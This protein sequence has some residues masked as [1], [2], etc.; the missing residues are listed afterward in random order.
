MAAMPYPERVRRGFS[1]AA[2]TYD[3]HAGLQR[4]VLAETASLLLPLLPA[5]ARILDAGSGT[6]YFARSFQDYTV[7]QLDSA[8]GMCRAAASF[9]PAVCADM[10]SLP[11]RDQ[12][13]EA[14]VS[15]LALQWIESPAAA[16]REFQ[17]VTTPGGHAA[18]AT[19]GPATLKELTTC[20]TKAGLPPSVLTFMP[21]A[22]LTEAASACGW[23]ITKATSAF[24]LQPYPSFTHLLHQLK[25]LGATFK[26][27]THPLTPSQLK[28][29][30]AH[31]PQQEQNRITATFE[32][33]TLLLQKQK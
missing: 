25:G 21:Q 18:I 5:D 14:V 6:G 2:A 27:R 12:S 20:F 9:A 1:R 30:E 23:Q 19:L 33:L 29:L 13:V 24:K 28:R 8:E 22:E 11:L 3:L 7:L 31:Y 16:L 10:A 4:E 15:S 17:R 26:N 32:L